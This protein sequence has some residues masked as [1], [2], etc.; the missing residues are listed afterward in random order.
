M[1]RARAA[2][3]SRLRACER[4]E[5]PIVFGHP[6]SRGRRR[7]RAEAPRVHADRSADPSARMSGRLSS[8]TTLAGADCGASPES[9]RPVRSRA[10]I[11]EV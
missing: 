10:R 1:I 7:G 2:M 6:A 4:A 11:H 9:A 5:Q 3:P 8:E